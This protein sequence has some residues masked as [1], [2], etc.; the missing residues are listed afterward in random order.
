M[1][2]AAVPQLRERSAFEI[3]DISIQLLRR[4]YATF[5]MF[6]MLASFPYWIVIWMSGLM[7]IMTGT[8]T[9]GAATPIAPNVAFNP[10]LILLVPLT[11]VWGFVFRGAMIVAAS[12]AYLN[13]VIEPGRALSAAVSKVLPIIGASLLLGIGCGVVALPTLFIG[14]VY[15]LL[16][17][18]AILPAILL[19]NQTVTDAFHRSRDLSL[20]FKW[21]ILGTMFLSWVIMFVVIALLQTVFVFVKLPPLAAQLVSAAASIFIGPLITITL[22]VLYYDQRVRK[23]GFDLEV[24]TRDLAPAPAH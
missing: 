7:S 1:T 17:Y 13:G 12:D 11:W 23:D 20:G 9:L 5:V 21:R 19:E 6:M 15:L 10:T 22:T 2:T 24:A 18:F 8:T 3:I 14:V 4:H 16:R